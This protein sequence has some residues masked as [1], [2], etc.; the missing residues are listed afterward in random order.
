M[1]LFYIEKIYNIKKYIVKSYQGEKMSS[2]QQLRYLVAVDKYRHFGKAAKS[3]GVSQPS[4]SIQIQKVEEEVGFFI[5][6]RN[7]K[8]VLPSQR[9]VLFLEEA[10]NVLRAHGRMLERAQKEGKEIQGRF[11]LALIPTVLPT[12]LPLFL[13]TFVSSYPSVMLH[14]E[15][16]T[17]ESCIQ[18]LREDRIDAA[19]LA[20]PLHERGVREQPLFY[21]EFFLFADKNNR[22]LEHREVDPNDLLADEI[23]LLK[24][25]H[26]LRNQI[27]SFCALGQHTSRYSNLYFEG[28]SLESLRLLIRSSTGYT[29]FPQLYVDTFH[30]N[31]RNTHVRPFCE[32]VPMRE[33]S[34]VFMRHQWKKDIIVA[35]QSCIEAQLPSTILRTKKGTILDI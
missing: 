6:D 34:M 4:L 20:T 30:S 17:T 18:A 27:V 12:L 31:E 28:N 23:W 19:I 21:E 3:C 26:C 11:R 24:D 10:R 15:E 33:I 9:G 16:R 25:G 2:I 1:V 14:I 32:P 7:K 8:P 35:L 5:F 13:E 29:L 22:L